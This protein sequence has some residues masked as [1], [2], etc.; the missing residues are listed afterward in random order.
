MTSSAKGTDGMALQQPRQFPT[1]GFEVV[2]PAQKIEEERLPLYVRDEYYPMRIGEVVH[3]HYQVVAKLGYGTSSTVWLARDL[4]NGKYW[5]LKVYI[6]TLQHNQELLVY[7]YLAKAPSNNPN[8][9]G[10]AHVRQS[11]E[12]FQIDGPAGKHD[13][14]VMTPLGMSLKT[15]QNMQKE[16][17]FP[18]EL[19]AGALEQ[20]FLG[21]NILHESDVIHTDLHAD[22]LLIALAD[23]S[24]LASVEQNEIDTPCARKQIGENFIHVSQYVLGGRGALVISDFGQA[25]IGAK[26][27]GNAMPVPYRAPEVILGMQW[28]PEVD[29]WSAGLLAWDLLEKEKLFD[30]YDSESQEHNDACHL[31]A[32]TAL[33][34]PPP[35]AFLEKA[36]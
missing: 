23:D 30:V 21:M 18:R 34:G 29:R 35:P 11:H 12:A 3:E 20:V 17:V 16:R 2:D 28:G 7:N 19:I 14:L 4:R 15:F 27:H 36:L 13:V 33:L 31:A 24:I 6:N 5:V 9:L 10:F 32:M 1:T 26:Q 22:N 25:R 8:Q